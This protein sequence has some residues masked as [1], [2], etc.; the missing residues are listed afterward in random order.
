MEGEGGGGPRWEAIEKP[1][2]AEG[3]MNLSSS[4]RSEK[5]LARDRLGIAF[6]QTQ[7]ALVSS[8]VDQGD[9]KG[10]PTVVGGGSVRG[11]G[12]GTADRLP[13]SF[14]DVGAIKSTWHARKSFLCC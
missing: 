5:V 1:V 4:N 7:S 6:D 8:K 11:S 12:N 14:D 13:L 2:T 9:T 3:K 10:N